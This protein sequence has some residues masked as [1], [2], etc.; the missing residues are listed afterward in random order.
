MATNTE[1]LDL[2][3]KNPATD[4]DDTFNIETMLNENWDKIDKRSAGIPWF[5][6]CPTSYSASTKVVTTQTGDFKLKAGSR[7]TVKFTYYNTAS[8]PYL[9]VD[10]TGAKYIKA[11]GTTA[12]LTYSWTSGEIVEFVFD[13]TYFIM[14]DGGIAD[15]SRYGVT[16]LSTST[17]STA[18]NLAAT[19]SAVKT[20]YDR[21]T[22][23]LNAANDIEARRT[24]RFVIGTSTAGWTQADCDYLCD[25]TDDQVEIN[26]AIEALPADGGKIV[27]LDGI[28]DISAAIINNNKNV[29]LVGCGTATVFK[30]SGGGFSAVSFT[31]NRYDKDRILLKDFV[32]DCN[33]ANSGVYGQFALIQNVIILN[34]STNAINADESIIVDCIIKQSGALESSYGIWVTSNSL[35]LNN[36]IYIL[37][38]YN[39]GIEV[40][41]SNNIII[42]NF[43]CQDNTNTNLNGR[44]IWVRA[45]DN[46]IADNE[47]Q[48]F[49]SGIHC[50]SGSNM[51][52]LSIIGNVCMDSPSTGLNLAY[53]NNS[54]IAENIC[55]NNQT[56]ICFSSYS[57]SSPDNKNANNCISNNVFIGNSRYAM[58]IQNVFNSSVLGNISKDSP[59][60]MQLMGSHNNVVMGNVVLRGDGNSS[61]Y[62]STQYTILLE[63]DWNNNEAPNNNNSIVYNN[64]KGKNY[65]SEGGTGNTFTG[66]KY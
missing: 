18:T 64:I 55:N 11:Y 35:V 43:C 46:F 56:G 39:H 31:S 15:T 22:T 12:P 13:G 17:S 25:G 33:N 19:P 65:V 42:G 27:V 53:V 37:P 5:G 29:S 54:V 34:C 23:A 48:Y 41:G 63:N 36:K 10:G 32:V 4:G 16:K 52:N 45:S 47:L 1:N 57:S 6:T 58:R 59:T 51:E 8:S 66:N 44:G 40:Y 50:Y 14:I 38:G 62:T 26:A 49:G 7:I 2:L 3:K 30:K 60:G 61:D 20:A 24:C 21:A 28:Y 9:N